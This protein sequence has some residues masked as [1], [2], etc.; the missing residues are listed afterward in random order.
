MRVSIDRAC[1][2]KPSARATG[3]ALRA[4]SPGSKIRTSAKLRRKWAGFSIDANRAV[5][6]RYPVTLGRRAS[7]P[8]TRYGRIGHM[9]LQGR[10]RACIDANNGRSAVVVVVVLVAMTVRI[11]VCGG[12]ALTGR[13]GRQFK[14]GHWP[15]LKGGEKVRTILA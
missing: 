6:D 4:S 5:P 1:C 7:R 15:G 3:A 13:V 2:S 14:V 12:S 11:V 10:C 8:T 9:S